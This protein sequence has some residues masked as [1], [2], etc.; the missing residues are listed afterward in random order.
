MPMFWPIIKTASPILW[1]MNIKIRML[2]NIYG[3]GYWPATGTI[4]AVLAMMISRSMAGVVPKL[5]IFYV[6]KAISAVPKRFGLKKITGQP[7]IFWQRRPKLLR[8]MRRDLAKPYIHRQ[9]TVKSCGSMAIG[10]GLT[11]REISPAR[12]KQ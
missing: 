9:M 2:R 10:M 12:S 1:L 7:D 8:V 5:A 3:C 6:L 11:R 4:F